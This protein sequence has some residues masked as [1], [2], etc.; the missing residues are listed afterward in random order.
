MKKVLLASMFLLLQLAAHAQTKYKVNLSSDPVGTLN[1][2]AHD[3]NAYWGSSTEFEAGTTV[4]LSGSLRSE[5]NFV[6]W[7][8]ENGTVV[9]DSL[10]YTFTMPAH[11]VTLVGHTEYD[12]E[13]PPGP[14]E[15]G[16]TDTWNRL[17]LRSLPEYGGAFTWGPGAERAQNWLV[18]TGYE[19]TVT[20]YPATGFK[21][22][23]FQ[24]D[25]K[26]VSTDNPYTF[27]MPER[28]MT[29]YAVYEYDPDAPAHPYG[30]K[31]DKESGELI[32]TDFTPGNLEDQITEVTR[33]DPWSSDW[34][35]IKSA[36]V[37]GSCLQEGDGWMTHC[38]WQA[39]DYANIVEYLDYS[40]TSGLTVIP[41]SCFSGKEKMTTFVMPA[42]TDSIAP[43]AFSKC[44][45]LTNVTCFATT[46]PKFGGLVPSDDKYSPGDYWNTNW[47]FDELILDNI[48]VHVPAESV[49]LYQEARG[50]K[51]FMI[52]PITQNVQRLTVN[53]PQ[54]AD[55]K[56]MFLEL[57]NM[58]TAQSLRYVITS[59]TSYTFNN[60]IRDTQHSLFLKNQRGEVL[61]RVERID[62]VDKDLE[63]SF[64]DL[65]KPIDL[66]LRLT[67]PGGSPVEEDN[68]TV[69]WT[70]RQGNYLGQ[71]TTLK[72][73]LSGTQVRYR[74]RLEEAL[75]RQYQNPA[76]SLVSVEQ[77]S[78]LI[79]YHLSLL[80]QVAISGTVTA[81]STGKPV[82]SATVTVNQM[83]NG[84]YATSQMV[85]TDAE[86]RWSLTAYEAPTTI[87]VSHHNYL[88][89][90]LTV[91]S[92]SPSEGAGGNFDFALRDITG[93]IVDLDLYYRACVHDGEESISENYDNY[94][95]IS[96]TVFDETHQCDLSGIMSVQYPMI[97][98]VDQELEQGTKLSVTAT[99]IDKEFMPV[100][101]T[102]SV[103]SAG[104]ATA[105]LPIV[106]LG[107]V[108]A[109]FEMTDNE[110]VVALLFDSEGQ[111]YGWAPY[112]G[113]SLTLNDIPDGQYRLITIGNSMLSTSINTLH[114]L[115]N[116]GLK[117]GDDYVQNMIDVKSGHIVEVSNTFIPAFDETG[118]LYTSDQTSFSVNK[119]EVSVGQY[120]TLKAQVDFKPAFEADNVQLIFDLPEGCELVEGSVMVGNHTAR[121]NNYDR[122]FVSINDISEAVRFCVIPTISGTLQVTA[123]VSADLNGQNTR[124]P[125]GS[126]IFSAEDLT[127]NVP[128]T[129]GRR[130]LPVTGMAVP[131][132]TVEVYDGDVLI[133]QTTSTGTGYWNTLCELNQPY[134]LSEHSIYAI[135]TIPEGIQMQ[136]ETK[137]VKVNRGSLT[138]VVSME[139]KGTDWEH[140]QKTFVFD[141]RT[142]DVNP[143]GMKLTDFGNF[144]LDFR[145]DFYDQND[146]LVND[147]TV[148][149]DVTLYLLFERRN[150]ESFPLKYN[151][152]Y[153]CWY[154]QLDRDHSN[155]PVNIDLDYAL[156]ADV[157]FDR[158]E[159][160]DRM[161]QLLSYAEESRQRMLDTYH[162]YDNISDDLENQ[163]L[164]NQLENLLAS[165]ALDD[166]DIDRMD[167]LVTQ[168]VGSEAMA[169]TDAQFAIDFSELD[170]LQSKDELTDAELERM[171]ELIDARMAD[172]LAIATESVNEQQLAE[173]FAE[174]ER[175]YKTL[176][177]ETRDSLMCLSTFFYFPDTTAVM[178]PDGDVSMLLAGETRSA[179]LDIKNLS[180]IDREQLLAE[181]YTE[182]PTT[183]GNYFYYLASGDEYKVID[184]AEKKLY[185]KTFIDND[186]AAARHKEVFWGTYLGGL[187]LSAF[188]PKAC[189]DKFDDLSR[190]IAKTAEQLRQSSGD[191]PSTLINVLTNLIP[192]IVDVENIMECLYND[193]RNKLDIHIKNAYDNGMKKYE[194]ALAKF[195]E[196]FDK[197]TKALST[198]TTKLKRLKNMQQ[199]LDHQIRYYRSQLNR[200]T[201]A[202][203]VIKWQTK[204]TA[205]Q[206][207]L[208]LAKTTFESTTKNLKNVK[209]AFETAQRFF[210]K[211]TKALDGFKKFSNNLLN[212][213]SMLPIKL[214]PDKS[215]LKK[216][217]WS[218]MQMPVIGPIVKLFP[219]IMV[220]IDNGQD[221]MAWD[222][223]HKAVQAVMPCEGEPEKAQQ[224]LWDCE[225]MFGVHGIA[226]ILHIGV[227]LTAWVVDVFKVAPSNFILAKALDVTSCLMGV[228][229][230]AA[231]QKDRELIELR[232]KELDCNKKPDPKPD[233]PNTND[234]N[235]EWIPSGGTLG[236]ASRRYNHPT[237]KFPRLWFVRD[238]SGYVYEAVNSNRVEG[239]TA[240]CYYK[241]QREDMYGDLH[242]EVVLWDAENYEQENPLFTDAD[243]RYQWD[244]PTGWWQ[245]KYE[246]EGYETTYSDWLPVPPPQLEVNMGIMQM[247]QPQ[248]Q[249][250]RAYAATDGSFTPS[251][252]EVQFDKY[253]D[254]ATLTTDNI[255][256]VSGGQA[257]SGKIVLLNVEEGYQKPGV[258]YASKVRFEP[259][260]PLK[261]TDK[262]QL[263]VSRRVES[264][265]GVPMQQDFT[266]QFDVEQRIDAL[267]ADTLVNI[268][269]GQER[270]LYIKATPAKA[271]QGKKVTVVSLSP[272]VVTLQKDALTLDQNGEAQLIVSALGQGSS[273]IR[274]TLADAELST[275]TLVT[276]RDS[277]SMQVKAPKSSR[278][279]GITMYQ[280]S[281]I[282]LTCSTAGARILYT[283]DGS[284]PCNT[285][286][287]KVLAYDGPII[288]TGDSIVIKA[289]AVANGMEDSPVVEFRY[290]GIQRPVSI[291]A[292]TADE[293]PS[294]TT[295]KMYFRLD[296]RRITRPE[297]GLNIERRENGQVRK[298]LVK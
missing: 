2:Y 119:Q 151:E 265:A 110:S 184:A 52:L 202:T 253:M 198:E 50:W 171:E 247:R 254:P 80:P 189:F 116:I 146:L 134:N 269:E 82:R 174:L 55:Y 285:G 70:D 122:L 107:K 249:K 14:H 144:T 248:V 69:T 71:G 73:Q 227:D 277:A 56:D 298:V 205:A 53:L 236:G 152:R 9:C 255:S 274:F 58:K 180:S 156:I 284:C 87:T 90:S 194:S 40:R 41:Y 186:V 295:P 84:L 142:G 95:N 77:S 191:T 60:L 11:D 224:L 125:I 123:I 177:E 145:V 183:D 158:Q 210:N 115:N 212:L 130:M 136:S 178:L 102:C 59:N 264:Y 16:Y 45:A 279:N 149:R 267:M 26:I 13:N 30:N 35:L 294:G 165:E 18:W 72:G 241:E 153:K 275:T 211:A 44:N 239:V 7:T 36:T 245:V 251:G 286:S 54:A 89:T 129:T 63:V 175:S 66:T 3:L 297:R 76:D 86:G 270:T 25:D 5:Y 10:K 147:T 64:T 32:M 120:V 226:D 206:D 92:I 160:E 38:D 133:G 242:D 192:I 237:W 293:N 221:L 83:L 163:A 259:T 203:D 228:F 240:T 256:I 47:A 250:V 34:E 216:I 106:Q 169:E 225:F 233:E 137:T 108:E 243:G 195:K 46:P 118:F 61:G 272:D 140:H 271:A 282:R 121:Y 162:M 200:V 215:V 157:A 128:E 155:M 222:K 33:R 43:Y 258:Q 167:E 28:D 85:K 148:I 238:P 39:F 289:M 19:F 166:A 268:Q 141:Y 124:Q 209:Q 101:A 48:I 296:G 266:Q 51:E 229:H 97:V 62:I 287:D 117:E 131:L 291:E 170:A 196:Q 22:V 29:L 42:T 98:L 150:E 278:L 81:A 173:L 99:S 68:F 105:T 276:V 4:Q 15:D 208:Q 223:T 67:A 280:G 112:R 185:S 100:T 197:A 65:K 57:V 132:S 207:K 8:D 193:G 75:G 159:F 79:T 261:L 88:K 31:W 244:V 111:L 172:V 20:A 234:P 188:L 23:G 24:L 78:S 143:S 37:A 218:I 176:T 182:V 139:L 217:P 21:F 161:Q 204:L 190:H 214:I 135:V 27:I 220:C 104:R 6:N 181:G 230:P 283:L 164:F 262:V 246:K 114:A 252:V 91:D 109:S 292:P 168:L 273:A 96:Y 187:S 213:F 94:E 219:A 257:L 12:P 138:P 281:E 179:Q 49:P 260:T 231:S 93:T 127:L 103:D 1:A 201:Q 263:T 17:Y 235:G 290:K 74:V 113:V 154:L 199:K 232:L 288:L 126:A